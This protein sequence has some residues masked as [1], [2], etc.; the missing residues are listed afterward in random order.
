MRPR[1]KSF[2]VRKA[3]QR[4]VEGM[5]RLQRASVEKAWPSIVG[6]GFTAFLKERFDHDD[7]MKKYAQRLLDPERFLFVIEQEGRLAAF[8]GARKCGRDDQ[9]PGFEW[10]GGAF[11]VAPDF[12]GLGASLALFEAIIAELRARGAKSVSGWCFA[13]NRPARNFYE[14]RGMKLVENVAVPKEY[15]DV[16]PH[17]AYGRIF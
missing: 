15:N 17:V 9:P 5:V 16:A 2:S 10:Q 7:Q 1:K 3:E 8:G 13:A 14:R 12:M 4:D 6:V 11:Y